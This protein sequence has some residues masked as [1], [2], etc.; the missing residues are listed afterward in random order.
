MSGQVPSPYEGKVDKLKANCEDS[1]LVSGPKPY[2]QKV[3]K[4]KANCDDSFLV[5]GSMPL[6][7]E[8]GQ[9]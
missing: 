3:D 8:S 1:L 5:S 4:L 7:A 2:E 9:A 6:P